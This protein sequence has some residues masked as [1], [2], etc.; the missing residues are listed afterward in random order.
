MWWRPCPVE[1]ALWYGEETMIPS[2]RRR[3]AGTRG[4]TTHNL[5]RQLRRP[6]RRWLTA[7]SIPNSWG[8]VFPARRARGL[9]GYPEV[10]FHGWIL[11]FDGLAW[12]ETLVALVPFTDDRLQPKK[13]WLYATI[14]I[15][16]SIYC[17]F[18]KFTAKK[19]RRYRSVETNRI[20]SE[21]IYPF[22]PQLIY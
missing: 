21:I 14:V 19:R 2:S 17:L 16:V 3:K 1:F 22:W 7:E 4:R 20:N 13:T 9:E 10:I 11:Q 5:N 12:E 15:V 8:K 18:F 6:I